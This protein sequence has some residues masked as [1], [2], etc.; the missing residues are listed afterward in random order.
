MTLFL[1]IIFLRKQYQNR[2]HFLEEMAVVHGSQT[3]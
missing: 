2:K 1:P 3:S